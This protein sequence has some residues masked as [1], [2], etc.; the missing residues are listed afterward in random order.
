ME[1]VEGCVEAAGILVGHSGAEQPADQD[2]RS[3]RPV[4][5]C[6]ARLGEHVGHPGVDVVAVDRPGFG[7]GV[8]VGGRQDLPV[9]DLHG[10]HRSP[11]QSAKELPQLVREAIGHSQILRRELEEERPGLG[12]EPLHERSDDGFRGVGRIEE[13][14]VH[15]SADGAVAG[16]VGIPGY[17]AGLVCLD[18]EAEAVRHLGRVLGELP[19]LDRSVIGAVDPDAPEERV[20]RVGGEPLAGQLRL[21]ILTVVDQVPPSRERPSGAAEIDIL[22]QRPPE[23]DPF[24]GDRGRADPLLDG[25]HQAGEE[26][27]LFLL[28]AAHERSLSGKPPPRQWSVAGKRA[29]S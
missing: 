18:H 24:L 25:L 8:G 4:G 6:E 10:I 9:A 7:K 23:L 19:R 13:E 11:R 20:L 2:D 22:G 5:A 17:R 3:A 27:E 14:R 29:W 1:T 21:R 16:P 12:S 28:G 26:L 15:L